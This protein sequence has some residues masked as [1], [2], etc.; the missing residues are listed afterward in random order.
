MEQAAI[1]RAAAILCASRFKRQPL[2]GLP[3]DCR[4]EGTSDGYAIQEASHAPIAAHGLGPIV[5]WKIGC[6]TP[7][8]QAY[9]GIDEPCAGAV[10]ASQVGGPAVRLLATDFVR[11]GVEC[12]IAVRLGADLTPGGAPYGRADVARA[13]S[14]CMTSIEIVDDRYVDFRAL[15]APTLIADNFFNAGCVLGEAR[16]IGR[17]FDLAALRGRMKVN[18]Q[19]IGAGTGANILGHPLD[20]LAW[21]ANLR[22]SLGLKLGAGTFVSLGSIVKVHWVTPGDDIEAEIDGLGVARVRF[23]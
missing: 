15:P 5:G 11:A 4:P 1:E 17:D 20:A 22:A 12:E 3:A 21:F 10:F 18:D 23:S 14:D 2:A 19:E 16:V 8:M 9:I 6:T 7:V 13:V